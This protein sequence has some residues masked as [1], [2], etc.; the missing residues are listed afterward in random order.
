MREFLEGL[1][2]RRF[3]GFLRVFREV[4]EFLEGLETKKLYNISLPTIRCESS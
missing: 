3:T 1:E 2:T 4:R